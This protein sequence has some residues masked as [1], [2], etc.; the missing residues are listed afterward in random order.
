MEGSRLHSGPWPVRLTAAAVVLVI[1]GPLAWPGY[2]LSYDMV[3]VPRQFLGW[4]LVAP[5]DALPRAVPLDAAVALLNVAIP[6]WLLQRLALAGLLYF[7]AVGAARLI[8]TPRLLPRLV[9]AVGYAW[10]P[11]LA[12]RL[13]LG[14]WALLCCYA[15]L[16]WIVLAVTELRGPARSWFH[17]L[18]RLVVAAAAAS[19]TPTGGLI[20]TAVTAV[21]LVGRSAGA[22]SWL[23]V[24]AVAPFNAPWIVAAA[25]GSAGGQSDPAGVAAFA[26]R[27]ENWSGVLGALLGTGGV[28]NR[29]TTPDSRSWIVT[30]IVTALVIGVAVLGWT[31]LRA[32][33]PPGMATRLAALAGVG[34]VLALAG[35]TAPGAALLRFL[36]VHVPGGGLLRDGQKFLLPYVLLLVLC[37]AF[38]V[39]RLIDRLGAQTGAALAVGALLLPILALPDLAWGGAG[40]LRPAS[41]PAD[42]ATISRTVAA[43]PGEVL[44]LPFAE[45]RRYGWNHGR[46]VID[47]WPRYL[48]APVV[49]DDALVVGGVP[50]AGESARALAVRQHL[51]RGGAAAE[52]G[53]EWVIVHGD[54]TPASVL[55]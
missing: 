40:A 17:G 4:Q 50:I 12:E 8:P 5:V 11:F 37:A 36:V 35:A 3:F 49:S 15:A 42:F 53:V 9:A 24:G 33:L 14:Q 28:W 10:T 55:A 2:V 54:A 27:A 7:A 23:A 41:Y 44:V 19:L 20:A 1:L 18:P 34:F 25:V 38:G 30:P 16:P 6:G 22:R 29:L 45:Y 32:T 46:V 26:V 52:L 13:L 39:D 31:R 51:Q 43:S 47:P 21:L 48:S